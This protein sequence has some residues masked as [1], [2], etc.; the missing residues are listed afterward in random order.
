MGDFF[1]D[2]LKKK[3]MDLFVTYLEFKRSNRKV[4]H[5]DRKIVRDTLDGFADT[6]PELLMN[7]SLSVACRRK[8][9]LIIVPVLILS[10][11]MFASLLRMFSL[12]FPDFTLSLIARFMEIYLEVTGDSLPHH[13]R[14]DRV[15][16]LKFNVYKTRM[17]DYTSHI[18]KE[19]GDGMNYCLD[20]ILITL[21]RARK[22]FRKMEEFDDYL[23]K[24]LG[25]KCSTYQKPYAGIE[26]VISNDPLIR[27]LSGTEE[28]KG[29]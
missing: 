22:M 19:F 14:T 5:R 26:A 3:G 2:I 27:G 8:W 10:F 7:L 24:G 1:L 17:L 25:R 20:E 4:V 28:K 6:L 18:I 15:I 16:L 21:S 12:L 13:S 29:E 23:A 9:T 11:D